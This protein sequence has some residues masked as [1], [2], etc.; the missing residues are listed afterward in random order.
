MKRII[1]LLSIITAFGTSCRIDK[2]LVTPAESVKNL[3]GKWRITH[4]TRNGA[5]LTARFDFTK[6]RLTFTD[7]AYTIDNQVPFV[8]NKN[9]FWSLDDPQYPFN[10]KFVPKDSTSKNLGFLYPIVNGRRN[11]LMTFSPGCSKNSYQYTFEK[12]D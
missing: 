12:E 2:E 8:V 11:I 1:L 4:V 3:N 7:S 10:I 9:G 5:D 6:F